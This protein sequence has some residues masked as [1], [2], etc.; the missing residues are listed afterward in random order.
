[1]K[2]SFFIF[3]SLF[4]ISCVYASENLGDQCAKHF[5]NLKRNTTLGSLNSIANYLKSPQ[6][7]IS[8][9]ETLPGS[10]DASLKKVY[11]ERLTAARK[12]YSLAKRKKINPGN[13]TI[14][15]LVFD[16][17]DKDFQ[18]ARLLLED[19]SGFAEAA[20]QLALSELEQ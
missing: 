8:P 4:L 1:M 18:N 12:F 17:V 9:A 15:T 7:K 20:V 16:F 3:V 11:Q 10:E 5:N 2:K 14:S 6:G 19:T 13:S